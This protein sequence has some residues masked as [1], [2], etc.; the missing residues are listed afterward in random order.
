M[1]DDWK[2]RISGYLDGELDPSERAAFE[3]QL[4]TDTALAHELDAIRS[5]K[6]VTRGMKLRELPDR[7]WERYWDG[8]YNRIERRIGWLLFSIGVIVFLAGAFY[9][10]AIVLLRNAADPLWVRVAV[11]AIGGGF[12][13]LV[14]SVVRERL[15]TWKRDPYREV[16]R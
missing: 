16:R 4:A 8:T 12:A 9:E 13:I 14:V 11:G 2:S 1:T 15:F 6:E 3:R 10:F 5:L 7:V